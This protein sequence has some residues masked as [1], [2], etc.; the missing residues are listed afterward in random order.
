V[1]KSYFL[2]LAGEDNYESLEAELGQLFSTFFL[3]F[4]CFCFSFLV[5]LFLGLTTFPPSLAAKKNETTKKQIEMMGRE[6]ERMVLD[7]AELGNG[8]VSFPFPFLIFSLAL[9]SHLSSFP[10]VST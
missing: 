10:V 8:V 3:C 5:S 4:F 7:Y 9:F 1:R 6:R 2:F